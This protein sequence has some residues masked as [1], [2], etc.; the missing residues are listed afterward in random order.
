[1]LRLVIGGLLVVL[2]FA[3][4]MAVSASKTVTLT[5]DGTTMRVTT[6]KSRVIDI[7]RENGFGVDERD[8]GER[9]AKPL[10]E[11]G[12]VVGAAAPRRELVRVVMILRERLHTGAKQRG[13]TRRVRRQKGPQPR[14]VSRQSHVQITP[15]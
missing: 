9:V 2:A 15:Q 5:V 14:S 7:V 6:M 8:D 4:G 1:M 12:F 11:G 13:E 10:R 3:G